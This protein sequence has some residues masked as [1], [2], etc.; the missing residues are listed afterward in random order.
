[1]RIEHVAGLPEDLVEVVLY[2]DTY[3][4]EACRLIYSYTIVFWSTFTRYLHA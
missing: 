1:M 2:N 4:Y 3:Q